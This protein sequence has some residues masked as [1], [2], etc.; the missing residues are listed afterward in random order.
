MMPDF[1]RENGMNRPRASAAG[2]FSGI[3]AVAFSIFL[4]ATMAGEASAQSNVCRRL[5]AQLASLNNGGGGN[6]TKFNQY[7]RAVQQQEYQLRKT[8]QASRRNGCSLFTMSNT[9]R[10]IN[11]SIDKMEANL[12]AL[13][14]QRDRYAGGGGNSDR[15]RVAIR[16]EMQRQGCYDDGGDTRQ[17]RQDDT[18]NRRRS[19]MEQLFGVRTYGDRG[20]ERNVEE[21]DPDA[22]AGFGT[23]RTLCVR[24]CDGYYFPIS[25]ST[26]RDRFEQDM[27]TCQQRCPGTETAL[28][29]H[30]MPNGEA[31]QSISYAT[32]EPY[33]SLPHAF[34]Y[35]KAV[36]P[37]CGCR[38]PQSNL[39]SIAGNE[40]SWLEEDQQK[41]PEKSVGTPVARMDPVMDPETLE[42]QAGGM[43]LKKLALLT[44]APTNEPTI[45]AGEGGRSGNIRIVG[46]AFFPV[47]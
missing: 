13:R 2:F 14:E 31:E 4:V 18:T 7:N 12:D 26:T 34:E 21:A 8:V 42:T 35:R 37:Q 24:T 27:E 45:A 41:Q 15:Q 25:F 17:A 29:F 10:R 22:I 19:L 33:A 32:G 5:E 16:R 40:P 36:N 38:A 46:P 43:S 9:C 23:F 39:Q 3:A 28:Y 44:G 11:S 6:S 1:S 20:D 47:Q 30:P